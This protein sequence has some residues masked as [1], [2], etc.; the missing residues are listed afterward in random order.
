[1][2]SICVLTE[3]CGEAALTGLAGK[4]LAVL[5]GRVALMSDGQAQSNAF[6]EQLKTAFVQSGGTVLCLP[7]GFEARVISA[8]RLLEADAA[9]YLS[10]DSACRMSVYG[11][12]GRRLT[13]EEEQQIAQGAPQGLPQP[14]RSVSLSPAQTYAALAR[15]VGGSL[16]NVAASFASPDPSVL[17]F[18]RQTAFS[19]GM[20]ERK[21]PR[22]FISR[23]GLTV[24]AQ[25]ERGALHPHGSLLDLCCACEL[26]DHKPLTVPFSASFTLTELAGQNGVALQR[27]AQGGHEPWQT[28]GVLLALRLLRHMSQRGQ[29]L[30]TLFGSFSF[31]YERRMTLAFNGSLERLADHIPCD[32]IVTQTDQLLFLKRRQ[33]GAV[34]TRRKSGSRCCLEV[35]APDAETARE[36]CGELEQAVLTFSEI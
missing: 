5:G 35:Q 21:T 16:E 31:P 1:M 29:A 12:N 4:L 2:K 7:D 24:A 19:L 33:A 10:Y 14:G 27:S 26:A 13:N 36:L 32:E 9:V 18:V 11:E 20:I 6:A 23:S 15:R 30:S 28:D 8:A 34:L 17:R 25:D 22:F 3:K